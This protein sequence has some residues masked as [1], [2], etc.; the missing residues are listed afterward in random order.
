MTKIS[1]MEKV[2]LAMAVAG[3]AVL[4]GTLLLGMW[5]FALIGPQPSGMTILAF[6]AAAGSTLAFPGVFFLLL[7]QQLRFKR[8]ERS[9]K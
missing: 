3:V 9:R 5:S 2:G 4:A 6:G 8:D 1:R 7:G